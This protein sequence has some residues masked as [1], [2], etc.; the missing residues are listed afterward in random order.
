[1]PASYPPQ[2]GPT[3][4][5]AGL[6]QRESSNAKRRE[7]TKGLLG[8]Q[9]SQGKALLKNRSQLHK[10]GRQQGDRGQA[11]ALRGG[12]AI[13]SGNSGGI[14]E[15]Q[16]RGINERLGA[17]K[18]QKKENQNYQKGQQGRNPC[19]R[20]PPV[21]PVKEGSKQGGKKFPAAWNFL[22]GKGRIWGGGS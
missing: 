13:N 3:G 17:Q 14:P 2:A 16:M 1:V 8:K 22:T 5:I 15:T 10:E 19:R 9:N 4:S 11:A 21:G 12:T 20:G 18:N 6:L 7:N